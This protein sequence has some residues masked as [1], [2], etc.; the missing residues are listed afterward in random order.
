M[1]INY[2]RLS[3]ARGA[4]RACVYVCRCVCEARV[5]MD[6]CEIYTGTMCV[7]ERQQIPF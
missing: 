5:R 2:F 6:T 7:V 4:L 1:L 3:D